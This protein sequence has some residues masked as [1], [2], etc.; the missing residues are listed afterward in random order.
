MDDH[1]PTDNDYRDVLR[2]AGHT[3][4]ED[5]HVSPLQKSGIRFVKTAVTILAVKRAAAE[6]VMLRRMTTSDPEPEPEMLAADIAR[7]AYHAFF[8]RIDAGDSQEAA[9]LHAIQPLIER[10]Q[11]SDVTGSVI[12]EDARSSAQSSWAVEMTSVRENGR[13]DRI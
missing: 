2:E 5:A 11:Q 12:P 6:A 3:V 10:I 1:E 8:A 4:A 9:F 13:D 7:D